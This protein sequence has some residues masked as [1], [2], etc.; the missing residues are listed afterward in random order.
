MKELLAECVKLLGSGETVALAT[1]LESAGSVP[2]GP[3]TQMLVR[4]D[5]SIRL[6]IGGGALEAEVIRLGVEAIRLGRSRLLPFDLTNADAALSDMICG[7]KGMVSV[8]VVSPK[9]MEVFA[10]AL[11]AA[12]SGEAGYLSTIWEEGGDSWELAFT[13]DGSGGK[14]VHPLPDGRWRHRLPVQGGGRLFLL[15]AGHVSC[16][17]AKIARQV[18]FEVTVM[19]DRADYSNEPRF[20]GCTC[21]VLDDMDVPPP[22]RLGD[23][24]YIVIATRGHLH[25]SK[26]LAWALGRGAEYVGMI[27]SRRKREIIFAALAEQGFPR[28]RLEAVYSPI[29]LEIGAQTPA[30]I[31]VSVV[32]QLIQKRACRWGER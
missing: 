10:A 27:G 18:G 17:I 13:R 11:E 20:P 32:G 14:G 6:T 5:G 24:D 9:Q 3:G 21:L 7:G 29:G 31:A 28:D 25:D 4:K 16:E 19:D 30:E 23:G 2:R 8:A 15:G 12:E 22:I 1:I 26:C